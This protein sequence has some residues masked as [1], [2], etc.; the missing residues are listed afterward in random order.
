MK[1]KCNG[2]VSV[3]A[4]SVLDVHDTHRVGIMDQKYCRG[5]IH[6]FLLSKQQEV[7]TLWEERF[8]QLKT[9]E[10]NW[11]IGS[12]CIALCS[13]S[14]QGVIFGTFIAPRTYQ[15]STLF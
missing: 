14:A 3:I 11:K 10:K 4:S 8:Y 12:P 6:P 2:H 5:T 9:K 13:V 7:G 15:R 1:R